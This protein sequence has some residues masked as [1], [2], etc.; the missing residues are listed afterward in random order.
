MAATVSKLTRLP[1]HWS[2]LERATRA[3][4]AGFV[5]GQ[6]QRQKERRKFHS[7]TPSWRRNNAQVI[8][9]KY[10]GQRS[11]GFNVNELEPEERAEYEAL[12]PSNQQ[13]YRDDHKQIQDILNSPEAVAEFRD[14]TGQAIA[15]GER[16]A[17]VIQKT[18]Q[19]AQLGFWNKGEAPGKRELLGGED[20]YKGDDL[21]EMG[22]A[23]LEQHREMREYAR[24]AAWEMPL[25]SSTLA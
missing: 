9:A 4:N 6:C 8:N 24:I 12:S 15:R 13:I 19:S 16:D 1:S 22:H 21:T 7:S 14:L 3:K 5:C 23:E 2:G 25:L 10:S 18:R 17:P 11:H 20:R